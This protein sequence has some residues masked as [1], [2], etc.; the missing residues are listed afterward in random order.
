M[1]KGIISKS[2]FYAIAVGEGSSLP[3][4]S[5]GFSAN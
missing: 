1:V 5:K 3:F 4:K 2:G